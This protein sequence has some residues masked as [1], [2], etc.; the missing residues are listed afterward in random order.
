LEE[1]YLY[2]PNRISSYLD[3]PPPQTVS[4]LS[5]NA[6]FN[7][8]SP[9]PSSNSYGSSIDI[10]VSPSSNKIVEEELPP[11]PRSQFVSRAPIVVDEW[12]PNSHS[13]VK[14][15]SPEQIENNRNGRWDTC[16]HSLPSNSTSSTP[17][18]PNSDYPSLNF[19][20]DSGDGLF[21]N[22]HFQA[23]SRD[24][25]SSSS[26]NGRQATGIWDPSAYSTPNGLRS[27]SQYPPVEQLR[28]FNV[29]EVPNS[30]EELMPTTP[31]L[32]PPLREEDV[33]R[34]NGKFYKIIVTDTLR[35]F[36][37]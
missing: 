24:S 12:S 29:A 23:E 22:R 13:E 6:T 2:S 3:Q 16:N 4:N 7:N 33:E 19:P 34:I 35:A 36:F 10:F 37:S 30:Q 32:Q 9:S 20:S 27:I 21:I 1:D 8:G 28:S 17:V 5:H 18:G 25:N 11:L 15:L 26:A 14:F 31:F